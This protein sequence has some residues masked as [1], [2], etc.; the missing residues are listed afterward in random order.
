MSRRG[1]II[2]QAYIATALRAFRSEGLKFRMR[3]MPD[4]STAFE[5]YECDFEE[6][7]ALMENER[8]IVL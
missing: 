2:T 4:G 5:P 8:D 3:R 6:G 1:T 7:E